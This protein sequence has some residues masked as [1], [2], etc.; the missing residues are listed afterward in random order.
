MTKLSELIEELDIDLDLDDNKSDDK[1]NDF[2]LSKLPEEHRAPVQAALDAAKANNEDL[3]GQVSAMN[4]TIKNLQTVVTQTTVKDKKVENDKVLGIDNEDHYAPALKTLS[5]KIISLEQKLG[6]T[7]LEG[8][9]KDLAVFAEKNPDV[10]KVKND[11]DKLANENPTLLKNIPN[12]FKLAKVIHGERE[13]VQKKGRK[14]HERKKKAAESGSETVGTPGDR[15]SPGGNAK[16]MM[17]AFDLAQTQ[18]R[19]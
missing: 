16:T 5:D 18:L 11:M 10:F 17:E 15:T 4:E 8:W 9:K 3:V 19:K 12:L 1:L 14:D 7:A 6:N 13:E 2:D